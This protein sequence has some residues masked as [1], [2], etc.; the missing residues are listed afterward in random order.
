[1]SGRDPERLRVIVHELRSPVAA[2]A[3]LA[4]AAEATTDL[5]LVRR[6]VEL[7]SAAVRDIER[8]LSDPELLSLRLEQVDVATLAAAFAGQDVT[9][10]AEGRRLVRGDPTRLRQAIA[11]L[12]ANGLRHGT[13]VTIH[14][15]GE[16]GHVVVAVSDDGPGVDTE[17]DPFAHGTSG[18]GST[19]IGLWLARGIVEAHGGSLE[20]ADAPDAGARFRLA[21][22][23]ASV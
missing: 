6:F 11:N 2:L 8:I 19:G 13:R 23:S 7:A 10:D 16:D 22:P 3:A 17:I 1:V 12:V 18:V 5:S 15:T 4:E 21:L 20:L 9:V 14:V